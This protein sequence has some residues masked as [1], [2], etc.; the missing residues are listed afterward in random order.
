MHTQLPWLIYI[1]RLQ[2]KHFPVL[3]I[4]GLFQI[5][6]ASKPIGGVKNLHLRTVLSCSSSTGWTELGLVWIK[7]KKNKSNSLIVCDSQLIIN[8]K[9]GFLVPACCWGFSSHGSG[10]WDQKSLSGLP[11]CMCCTLHGSQTWG[12]EQCH[13]SWEWRKNRSIAIRWDFG[14][15]E[16]TRRHRSLMDN[17][18][19]NLKMVVPK[20]EW[21]II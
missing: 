17:T 13:L 16:T 9:F 20:N 11:S 2:Q 12:T 19:K 4:G 8:I 3:H 7:K 18:W 5:F 6:H 1:A 10:G 21:C 15:S 14:V